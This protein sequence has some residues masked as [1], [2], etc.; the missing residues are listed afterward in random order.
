MAVF[1]IFT[2]SVLGCGLY[3]D[4]RSMFLWVVFCLFISGKGVES[5]FCV[6]KRSGESKEMLG[7]GVI[8]SLYV[9]P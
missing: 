4:C 8:R 6:M 9:M 7:I 5:R 2:S 1:V 3:H